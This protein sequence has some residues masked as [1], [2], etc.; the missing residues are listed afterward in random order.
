MTEIRKVS[1]ALKKAGFNA[2]PKGRFYGSGYKLQ[3]NIFGKIILG[4]ETGIQEI[5]AREML[6]MTGVLVNAGFAVSR[7]NNDELVIA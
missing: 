3:T 2:L 7:V 5:H 4:Y 6:A 1:A